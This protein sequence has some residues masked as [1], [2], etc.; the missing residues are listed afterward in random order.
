MIENLR[1]LHLP[2]DASLKP[3]DAQLFLL[4]TCQRSLVVGFDEHPKTILQ[5]SNQDHE[6]YLGTHAYTFLLETICG[7]RSQVLGEY[8]VVS[9]FKQAYAEYVEQDGRHVGIMRV[10]EKLFKDAKTVRSAHLLEIGS[11]T[12]GGLARKLL[13]RHCP[14]QKGR[15]LI[16]GSGKLA[17]ESLK[18]LTRKFDVYLSA[19]NF[20]RV[21]KLHDDY[22]IRPV[23]W[24]SPNLY[25][26]FS[27]VINTIGPDAPL[28][29]DDFFNA[30]T[31]RHVQGSRAFVDLGS[32][33][34]LA[35]SLEVSHGVYRLDDVF[36]F[37]E[38]L[39]EQKK[40]KLASA[41]AA[42]E[43]IVEKRIT[44]PSSEII[45]TTKD[46]ELV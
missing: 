17:E 40:M 19:R 34:A 7:L 3:A 21:A 11:H 37:Q 28:Y 12:Y 45:L 13:L 25:R 32:P 10:L 6:E 24:F 9:Q 36:S 39:D 30:W 18:L 44:P 15:V 41:Q 26:E 8:E 38:E 31:S 1:L 35:T 42:I 27:L 14:E 46:M 2:A 33:S 5:Q 16:M 20:D 22:G 29:Q 43:N 23:E 4:R